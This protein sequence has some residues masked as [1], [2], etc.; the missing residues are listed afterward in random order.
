MNIDNVISSLDFDKL[1]SDCL[2]HSSLKAYIEKNPKIPPCYD[3]DYFEQYLKNAVCFPSECA[4][5]VGMNK[6]DIR[7]F[8]YIP[9]FI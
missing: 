4:N 6:C 9:N 2:V 8:V 1:K 5:C 3:S 7:K